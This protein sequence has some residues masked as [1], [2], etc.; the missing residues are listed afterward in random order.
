VSAW[1]NGQTMLTLFY[2]FGSPAASVSSWAFELDALA[3]RGRVAVWVDAVL[4][5]VPLF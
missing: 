2:Y 1:W 4:D 5:P 3:L